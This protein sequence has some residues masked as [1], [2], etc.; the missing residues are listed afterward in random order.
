MVN[1]FFS[2]LQLADECKERQDKEPLIVVLDSMGGRQETA[3]QN[4]LEY[5]S[6]EWNTNPL[7]QKSKAVF[8]FD[9]AEMR[10][11]VPNCP[12]QRDVTSCGLFL[13]HYVSKVFTDL[14]RYSTTEGYE[15]LQTWKNYNVLFR[16]RF[17]I[18]SLLRSIARDQD[19]YD[20]LTFPDIMFFQS[21][22]VDQSHKA[23]WRTVSTSQKDEDWAYFNAYA[24]DAAD[25]QQDISLCR[26]YK[27]G[28]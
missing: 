27:S 4:V 21:A 15:N 26:E 10:V 7:V 11:L 3:V 17:D 5:L 8:P 13:I 9:K 25:K 16:K 20:L 1:T 6:V 19:R 18:A 24:K 12:G 28:V 14:D 2:F 22:S 23:E